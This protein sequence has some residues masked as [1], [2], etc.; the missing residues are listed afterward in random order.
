[1]SCLL[2]LLNLLNFIYSQLLE[3]SSINGA[4]ILSTG[5]S[6]ASIDRKLAGF[7]KADMTQALVLHYLRLEKFMDHTSSYTLSSGSRLLFLKSRS[8]VEEY[9]GELSLSPLVKIK[10]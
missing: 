10:E 4:G 6:D 2:N 3:S 1:M 9:W 7:K 5:H 8:L